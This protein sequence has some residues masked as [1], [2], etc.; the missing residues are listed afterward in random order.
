MP[1]QVDIDQ[2]RAF[3]RRYS[4]NPGKIYDCSRDN[5]AGFVNSLQAMTKA[6]ICSKELHL[7]QIRATSLSERLTAGVDDVYADAFLIHI[8]LIDL[9]INESKRTQSSVIGE[10]SYS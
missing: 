10:M 6:V 8:Q 3:V 9:S 4:V 5:L 2:C 7:M 1:G